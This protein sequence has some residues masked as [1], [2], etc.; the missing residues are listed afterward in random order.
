[1]AFCSGLVPRRPPRPGELRNP[2]EPGYLEEVGRAQG[3]RQLALRTSHFRKG[4]PGV[5]PGRR[6]LGAEGLWGGSY[7]MSL[8]QATVTSYLDY[9]STLMASQ[10]PILP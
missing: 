3:N 9:C 6:H 4:S 1:M 2:Q 8:V 10:G 7:W 5:C